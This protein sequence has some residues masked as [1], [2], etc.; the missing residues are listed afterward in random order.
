MAYALERLGQAAVVLG[1]PARGV[2]LAG[3][4][5]RLREAV[6]GGLTVEQLRWEL[7]D[8]RD[9]ARRVLTETEIDVAWARGRVMTPEQAVAHAK[10]PT[11]EPPQATI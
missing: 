9:A 2:T 4:A 1:Q 3:A 7:E 5:C 6:G 11:L 10:E 8:P